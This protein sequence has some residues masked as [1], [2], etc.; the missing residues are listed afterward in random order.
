MKGYGQFC[1]VAMA[2]EVVGERWTLLVIRELMC[3]S[4]R[5]GEIQNGVPLMSKSVLA[6]RLRALCDAG[7]IERRGAEYHL[8]LAGEELGPIVEA[9][10]VWGKRW[11]FQE[12]NSKDV[13]VGLLVWDMRRRIDVDALPQE[14]VMVQIDF[15]GAPAGRRRFWLRLHRSEVDLCLT[16]PGRAISVRVTTTPKT[17]AAIWLG[18]D[19]WAAARQRGD[20]QVDGASAHVRALPTWLRLSMFAGVE[21]PTLGPG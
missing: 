20:L 6:Q 10:G 4:H 7:V 16:N 1:P 3:G 12:L 9:C 15:R 13:D 17:M 21:R 2:L 8:T 11:A 19:T 18:D 5:F 14:E